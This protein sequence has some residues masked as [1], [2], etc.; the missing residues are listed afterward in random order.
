L[1]YGYDP[2]ARRDRHGPG[3]RGYF[4]TAEEIAPL[5][6][7]IGFETITVAGVEP[8]IGADDAAYNGLEE[9]MRGAW[10]ELLYGI[11]TEP[12]IVAA[13]RHILYV[14]RKP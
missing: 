6:E 8:A 7:S 1:A 5:H 9:P 10:L 11:S 12:S 2:P 14:G 3:F 4:A 13:S